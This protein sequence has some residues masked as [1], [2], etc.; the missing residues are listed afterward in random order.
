MNSFGLVSFDKFIYSRY[1][2]Y[3]YIQSFLKTSQKKYLTN[4]NWL[5][6]QSLQYFSN[7][8]AYV[9]DQKTQVKII[10]LTLLQTFYLHETPFLL[11]FKGKEIFCVFNVSW[12]SIPNFWS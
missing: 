2:I 5:F 11:L 12:Y 7:R 9:S 1:N 4:Q 3:T 8:N 6:K 10:C